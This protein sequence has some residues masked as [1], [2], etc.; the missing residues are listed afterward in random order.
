VFNNVFTTTKDGFIGRK[1]GQRYA[2]DRL[3]NSRTR[4]HIAPMQETDTMLGLPLVTVRL[5]AGA[6][7]FS[8]I[9]RT[10]AWH[11]I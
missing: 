8:N 1:L 3:D 7:A 9:R 11:S 5:L 6:A 10:V 4:L 2:V